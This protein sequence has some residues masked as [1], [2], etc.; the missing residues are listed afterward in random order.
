MYHKRYSQIFLKFQNSIIKFSGKWKELEK[1]IILIKATQ[2]KKDKHNMYLLVV[3][4]SCSGKDC[5]TTVHSP[6]NLKGRV[7]RE[8]HETP[9]EGKIE[10]L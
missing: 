8:T 9:W 1:K 2:T 6:E 3:V 4:I 10:I 5:H 7:L